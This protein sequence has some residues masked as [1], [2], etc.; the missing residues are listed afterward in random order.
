MPLKPALSF[1]AFLGVLEL[2]PWPLSQLVLPNMVTPMMLWMVISASEA[3]TDRGVRQVTS[4]KRLGLPHSGFG[5]TLLLGCLLKPHGS[6]SSHTAPS[7]WPPCVFCSSA[8]KKPVFTLAQEESLHFYFFFLHAED[9]HSLAPHIPEATV[10]LNSQF[11][12]LSSVGL[13]S[14][15]FILWGSLLLKVCVLVINC[16]LALVDVQSLFLCQDP[17][18]I[19][20]FASWR[21][22][23]MFA[24]CRGNHSSPRT[25]GDRIVAV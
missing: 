14:D 4:G 20:P 12:V 11:L 22:Q 1:P 10:D 15:R 9:V 5:E 16:G 8:S 6:C 3:Q 13:F 21:H 25:L 7:S 18:I 17:K 23:T 24:G 19:Y 2:T